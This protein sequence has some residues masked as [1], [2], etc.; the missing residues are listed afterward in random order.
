MDDSVTG[1]RL[2]LVEDDPDNL[3]ALTIIL[4]KRYA[5]FPYRSAVDAL[6]AVDAVKPHVLVLDIG[7][8]PID[9]LQCLTE[10]RG[11][12]AYCGVPAVALTGYAHAAERKRFLDGGFQAVVTKPIRDLETLATLIT[13]LASARLDRVVGLPASS[14]CESE[15][16]GRCQPS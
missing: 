4:G 15:K 7:M 11:N 6:Q 5:V 1:T 16:A 13:E 2:L 3:E 9:G 8:H 10:I 14:V 12:P